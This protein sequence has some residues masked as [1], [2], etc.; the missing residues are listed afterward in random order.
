MPVIGSHLQVRMPGDGREARPCKA[1]QG[2]LCSILRFAEQ[3]DS[4]K[5]VFGDISGCEHRV[6]CN[7]AVMSRHRTRS[8]VK[9]TPGCAGRWAER[10]R[11]RSWTSCPAAPRSRA[12][13]PC[14]CPRALRA[15]GAA[16]GPPARIHLEV[17]MCARL[18]TQVPGRNHNSCKLSDCC[19]CQQALR[20]GCHV[21][22]SRRCS[23]SR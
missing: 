1:E 20:W 23:A 22:R 6:G 3:G 2:G 14:P 12:P 21:G 11:W 18:Q 5:Q 13:D 16:S 15:A 17:D 9:A 4:F 19:R 10:C 8:T 7:P